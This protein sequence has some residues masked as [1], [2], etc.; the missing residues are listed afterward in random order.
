MKTFV[1]LLISMSVSLCAFADVIVAKGTK[2]TLSVEYVFESS[3]K[4][5]DKNDQHEWHVSRVAKLT[6]QLSAETAMAVPAMHAPDAAQNADMKHMQDHVASAQQKMAPMAADIEKLMAKCGD[7]EA[8]MTREIQNY[9][10]NAKMTPELKSAKQD[11]QAVSAQAQGGRYQLWSASAQKGTYSIDEKRHDVVAD[12]GCMPSLHCTRDMT[13]KGDGELPLPPAAKKDPKA[14]T[15]FALVEVDALKNTVVM[16]LPTPLMPL[17]YSQTLTTNSP[18]EKS[19]TTQTVASFPGE[20]KPITVALTGD[21][22]N[23]SGTQSFKINSKDGDSG[24]LTV[25]WR[26]SPP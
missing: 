14:A 19:G 21:L 3:G 4:Q 16:R 20:I 10:M 22:K 13:R 11:V 23:Q 25:K 7:D 1:V 17:P 5:Q 12:P 15:G 18:E 8:C 6:A 26:F 2:A 24:T 9:G